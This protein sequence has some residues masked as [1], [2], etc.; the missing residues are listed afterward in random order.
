LGS[1]RLPERNK[2]REVSPYK[3]TK[4]EIAI[5]V[6]DETVVLMMIVQHNAIGGKGLY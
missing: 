1:L 6:A 3:E 5:K 2:L 4:W